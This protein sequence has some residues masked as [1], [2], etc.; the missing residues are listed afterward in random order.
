MLGLLTS[1]WYQ[2]SPP[3]TKTASHQFSCGSV[4]LLFQSGTGQHVPLCLITPILVTSMG[5]I[6]LF[7]HFGFYSG[8]II[9]ST[10]MFY[11]VQAIVFVIIICRTLKPRMIS[12]SSRQSLCLLHKHFQIT[13]I[14]IQFQ[15]LKLFAAEVKP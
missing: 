15:K 8:D 4:Y 2:N 5:Q 10:D 13:I 6:F 3:L 11:F 12:A 7:F 1:F 14:F 9:F